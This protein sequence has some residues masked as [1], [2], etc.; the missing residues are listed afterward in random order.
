MNLLFYTNVICPTGGFRVSGV[1]RWKS[2]ASLKYRISLLQLTQDDKHAMQLDPSHIPTPLPTNAIFTFGLSLQQTITYVHL[3]T[4]LLQKLRLFLTDKRQSYP[5]ASRR[6]VPPD[7]E[8]SER[9]R[10]SIS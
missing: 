10:G 1:L 7:H 9:R 4:P 5:T 3:R 8:Q 6:P 2:D